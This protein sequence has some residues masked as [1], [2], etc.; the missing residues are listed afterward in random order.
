MRIGLAVMVVWIWAFAGARGVAAQ[1]RTSSSRALAARVDAYVAPLLELQ[2]FSGTILTAHGD[3]ILLE[4]SYGLADAEHGIPVKAGDVFRIASISKSFTKGVIGRLVDKHL[5]SL[6]DSISRWWP[7]MPSASRITVRMIVEHRSGIPNINSLPYDEEA[8]EPNT[9]ARV[10]DSI[11]R[12]PLDFEPGARTR[13]SNGGYAVL[14]RIIEL[15]TGRPY[16]DVVTSELFEPLHLTHTRH[17]ADGLIVEHLARGYA[18]SPERPG[19]LQVAPFQEMNT[20]AGGGSLVSSARD[21]LLW[22]HAIGRSPL[23]TSS[24][25]AALFP[26]S[27][28]TFVFTGRCPGYNV[29]L[30]H[31]RRRDATTIVLV[32]NYAGGMVADVAEAVAALARGEAPKALPVVR[33]VRADTSAQR[34]LAGTYTL[35]S[36]ALPVPPGTIVEL[37]V[38]GDHLVVYLGA[39]PV[40]VLVPQGP[41][42][43]LA[44]ALWS[45][46][47]APAQ[48]ADSVKVRALYRDQS[49]HARRVR[50]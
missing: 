19:Q 32:N 31:D 27:D 43:Y 15:V 46:V 48:G 29:V 4:R 6:D 7:N 10:V 16:E 36:G 1:A 24:S 38:S 47:E 22:A 50:K 45:M 14:A 41:R 2:V 44:R 28:S 42:T 30:Q 34:A 39:V 11:V 8:L 25:W 49:F 5:L 12:K 20:K 9:L 40:D 17:G 33:P 21:L 13:Y 35:P 23:L 26:G 18:P 3:S 37:R